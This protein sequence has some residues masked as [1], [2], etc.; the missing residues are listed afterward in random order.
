MTLANR[1][2][3]GNMP[4]ALE[5]T[6][7]PDVEEAFKRLA[8]EPHCFF[9][10]SAAPRQTV[11]SGS[12]DKPSGGASLSRYSFLGA[13]PLSFDRVAAGNAASLQIVRDRLQPFSA[14]HDPDLPPFQGGAVMLLGYDLHRGFEKI[15]AP[16]IDEF[17]TPVVA[18]G[19]YDT[20]LAF[21]HHQD[22]AWIISHGIGA[23]H[24]Q[25]REEKARQKINAMQR[26]LELPPATAGRPSR[27]AAAPLTPGQLAPQFDAGVMPKL[28]SNFSNQDYLHAVQT[29]IDYIHAGDIFQVNLSQRLLYPEVDSAFSLYC[30]LRRVNPAPFAAYFDT[31]DFQIVS[32]S[33]ERFV[34]AYGNQVEARP[35]KGTRSRQQHAVAD[36]F[37]GDDLRASVK[38][39]AENTMIV[40]LLRNDL[41]RVC[42][43]SSVFVSQLCEIETYRY[44]Q[45]LV[46]VIQGELP[47][48]VTA[49]DLV[50]AAFPGGSITG[51]PKVR[52][53]EIIAALEP[54][55]RGPY[56]GSLGY[57]GFDGWLDLNILIRTITCGRGWRQFPVGGGIVAQSNPRRELE[58]T[59][60]KAQGLLQ[61]MEPA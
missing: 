8:P 28:T 10:D 34:R 44:V 39:L 45:H 15:A 57:A 61:A 24:P 51:A 60:H 14:A 22:R 48:G 25:Q 16:R 17:K 9:L 4:Y 32:A 1:K 18:V 56:C 33:P 7:A 35:I 19:I 59:W 43:P 53:M 30:R 29:A 50:A 40:D 27:P 41:S 49:L 37:A 36:L 46:S 13:D 31:G 11:A 47:P 38:D 58:E 26:L 12:Q 42:D 3:S 52:A 23:Q 54:T 6:P 2:Q 5:L 55:S 21:D 20:I